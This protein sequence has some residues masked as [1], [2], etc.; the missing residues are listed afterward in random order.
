[1]TFH[2]PVLIPSL[3]RYVNFREVTNRQYKNIIKFSQNAD[4]KN[5][6]IYFNSLIDELNDD[7]THTD[8]NKI[9]KFCILLMVRS[10]SIGPEMKLTL[11]CEETGELYTGTIDLNKILEYICNFN[12]IK[13]RKVKINSDVSVHVDTPSQLY[14]DAGDLIGLISDSISE[15][16]VNQKKWTLSSLPADER[17]NI[18]NKLPGITFMKVLEY[19]DKYI[20][21]FDDVVIFTDKSPHVDN[22]DPTE[23][24]LGLYDNS[25]YDFIK[26]CYSID[27]Q[28]YYTL[29]YTLCETMKFSAEY[30]ESI[31]PIEA[32]LFVSYKQAEVA[33][34]NE[35]NKRQSNSSPTVGGQPGGMD[36]R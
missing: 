9:D 12:V 25:M 6:E 30:I 31:T 1:M 5:L 33:R 11:T 19:A 10:V 24:K 15:V 17:V 21:R 2:F 7:I 26:M 4:D 35:D 14:S 28:E 34:Q 20:T 32:N 27:L 29:I 16:I 23:Y 36:I 8:I 3:N 13:G 18:V 22:A